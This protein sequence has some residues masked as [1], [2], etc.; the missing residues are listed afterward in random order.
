MAGIREMGDVLSDGWA[1]Q[2]RPSSDRVRSVDALR[3]RDGLRRAR[4]ADFLAA[5]GVVSDAVS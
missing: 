1:G 4:E 2:E 3:I 5:M